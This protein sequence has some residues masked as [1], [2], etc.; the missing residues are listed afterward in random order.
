M[1]TFRFLVVISAQALAVLP[2]SA[3]FPNVF[4]M[5]PNMFHILIPNMFYIFNSQYVLYDSQYVYYVLI[6]TNTLSNMLSTS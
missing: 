4:Y 1:A 3:D 5:I 6:P 2:I